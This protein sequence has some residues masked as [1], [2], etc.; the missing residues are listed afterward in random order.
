MPAAQSVRSLA[1]DIK[2]GKV[3]VSFLPP[4]DAEEV[5]VTQY[6]VRI[7]PPVAHVPQVRYVTARSGLQRVE[8]IGL[9]PY[10]DYKI[11]VWARSSDG[12]TGPESS[13]RFESAAFP[14]PEEFQVLG[15]EPF[16]DQ[17]SRLRVTHIDIDAGG[18]RL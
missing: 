13:F 8:I 9:E 12:S 3:G 18:G 17:R 10:E 15:V 6:G 5:G 1:P 14:E 2:P 7:T 4:E 16:K 11:D